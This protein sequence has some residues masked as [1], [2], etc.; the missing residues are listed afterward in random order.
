MLLH[1]KASQVAKARKTLS[2]S[3]D[4]SPE[5]SPAKDRPHAYPSRD[6]AF[7]RVKFE[8][9]FER[10]PRREVYLEPARLGFSV[11]HKTYLNSRRQSAPIWRYRVSSNRYTNWKQTGT[12]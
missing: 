3:F 9:D 10:V 8:V 1:P 7:T 5:L 11:H 4:S 12:P 2:C 6:L